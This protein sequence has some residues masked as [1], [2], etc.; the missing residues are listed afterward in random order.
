MKKNF[1]ETIHQHTDRQLKRIAKDFYYYSSEERLLAINELKKRNALSDELEMR[2]KKCLKK[3]NDAFENNS[4]IVRL[5]DGYYS[6]LL[7]QG[8]EKYIRLAHHNVN[9]MVAIFTINFITLLVFIFPFFFSRDVSFFIFL[10]PA[11]VFSLIVNRFFRRRYTDEFM[12]K[13]FAKSKNESPEVRRQ[14]TKWVVIYWIST[15]AFFI[16]AGIW[17]AQ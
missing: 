17:I 14:K 1:Q 10:P 4:R 5:L 8:G 7:R 13:L 3:Q 11:I 16:L 15:V 9:F 12:T 2:L 6:E